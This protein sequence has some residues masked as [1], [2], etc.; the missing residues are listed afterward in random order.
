MPSAAKGAASPWLEVRAQK[1][2]DGKVRLLEFSL[3]AKGPRKGTGALT[4]HSTRK[5]PQGTRG[6]TVVL[7]LN[8]RGGSFLFPPE[9]I[10]VKLLITFRLFVH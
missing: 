6:T 4:W 9:P 8:L 3:Y 5:M 10:V 7:L 1:P 2:A